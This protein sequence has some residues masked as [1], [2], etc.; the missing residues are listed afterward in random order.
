MKVD[1]VISNARLVLP[2]AILK[3]GVA[4]E[5]G[6]IV[7]IAKDVNLPQADAVI[8]ARVTLFY[9]DASTPTYTSEISERQNWKIG[10]RALRVQLLGA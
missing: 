5:N 10:G 6:Q 7:A 2:S 4:I 3:A 1:T 8:D 9:R